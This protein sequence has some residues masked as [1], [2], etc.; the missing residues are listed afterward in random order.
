MNRKELI[1]GLKKYF[2]IRELV[3]P[4]VYKTFGEKAWQFFDLQFLEMLYITRTEINV[5]GM[6][7]NNWHKGGEFSQRG[8]RCNICQ[9][10]KDKSKKGQIY[11]S[12][13]CN[14]AA[15]DYDVPGKTAEFVRK[16]IISHSDKF[17]FKIRLEN[18]VSWVHQ[19]IYDDID[20]YSK[21]TLF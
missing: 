10:P 9:I 8:L 1:N 2:D 3:C 15:L 17:P 5:E 18:N 11:M 21:V 4:D 19:D 7:C 14:G 16:R 12:A 13:H 6:I 20:S